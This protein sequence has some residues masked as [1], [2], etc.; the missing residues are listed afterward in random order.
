MATQKAPGPGDAGTCR[1]AAL[2]ATCWRG[3]RTGPRDVWR[4]ET[5]PNIH[6]FLDAD[7]R[8]A[9][10]RCDRRLET[11]QAQI[12]GRQLSRRAVVEG[13]AGV[14]IS[15]TVGLGLVGGCGWP[16][17]Q[18]VKRM[19]RIGYL[20]VGPR[21]ARAEWVD[22]F[23]EGL[24]SID[25]VEGRTVEVAWRFTDDG[26]S[27]QLVTLAS[28]LVEM[29]VDVLVASSLSPA[30]AAKQATG[31]IPIVFV[32]VGEVFESGLATSLARPGSNATG[33]TNHATAL[34]GKRLELLRDLV[35]TA[36]RVAVVRNPTN[37]GAS[38]L[39]RELQE[40]ADVLGLHLLAIDVS[41]A[42]V[43]SAAFEAAV[44]G[45]ADVLTTLTDPFLSVQ[46]ARI[47]ELAMAHKLV[48]LYPHRDF[49]IAGGLSAYG[50]NYPM[51]YRR[52]ASYVGKILGGSAPSELPIEQPAEFE[53]VANT[54]AMG[55]LGLT[56]PPHV[57]AQVTEWVQ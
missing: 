46:R 1:C 50:P 48:A 34:S 5:A 6:R 20:S 49:V 35:P 57:A 42:D 9:G 39:W 53:F 29:R 18:P 10:L 23:L 8:P 15:A 25:L 14:G 40:T 30:V 28:E 32:G 27:S 17:A 51:L 55:R 22:A 52:A 16:L 36:R 21:A 13:L 43:I 7:R 37:P 12:L 41:L 45:Q 38:S 33:L 24:R 31:V 2:A 54:R 47:T 3:R 26:S 44:S 56:V 19:P 4:S 11:M